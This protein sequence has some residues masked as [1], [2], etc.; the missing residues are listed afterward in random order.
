[1][2]SGPELSLREH[3]VTFRDESLGHA[4]GTGEEEKPGWEPEEPMT[5]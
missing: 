4:G 2:A 1:M 3:I 5:E